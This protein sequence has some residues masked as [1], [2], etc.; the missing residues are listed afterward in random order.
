MDLRERMVAAYDGGD[1]TREM[2]A[3]RFPVSVGTVKK[4]LQ[5]RRAWGRSGRNIIGPDASR[6]FCPPTVPSCGGTWPRSRI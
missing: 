6:G 2:V 4:L 5:Q 3:G 1:A